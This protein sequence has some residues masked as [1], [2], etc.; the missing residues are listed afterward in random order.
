MKRLVILTAAALALSA[1][2]YS[3]AKFGTEAEAK[4]MLEK[5]VANIKSNKAGAL[6]S[7]RKGEG[8]AVDRDLYVYCAN[9]NDGAFTVHPMLMG[10]N[11]KEVKDATGRAIGQELMDAAKE[12]TFNTV[13]YLWPRPGAD[14]TPIP[15][16]SFVTR[17]ADQVCGVGYYK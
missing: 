16:V 4:A 13:S 3:Q 14:T 5:A 12:D 6:E 11:V 9:A 15:K 7:M 8:G 2:A 10:K 17:V 1:T